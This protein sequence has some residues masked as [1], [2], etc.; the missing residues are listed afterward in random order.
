GMGAIITKPA[1]AF[2]ARPAR[3]LRRS[4]CQGTPTDAS[5]RR[6]VFSCEDELSVRPAAESEIHVGILGRVLGIA[7]ADLEIARGAIAPVHEVMPVLRASGKARARAGT[8]DLLSL[9]RDEHHFALDHEHELVLARVP[10]PHRGL[11]ARRQRGEVHA[12]L[13]EPHGIAEGALLA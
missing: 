4:A 5:A 9:V 2:I 1:L 13:R 8:Q 12:D 7:V 10:V 6:A 11:L 3:R